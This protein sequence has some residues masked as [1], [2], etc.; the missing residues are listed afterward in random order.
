MTFEQP[1]HASKAIK[2]YNGAQ[3]DERI[4]TI[5]YAA[6]VHVV[7]KIKRVNAIGKGK[8]LR[9]GGSRR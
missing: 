8:T 9:M 1:E 6:P 2:D 3:L 4:L 7:P 5:E